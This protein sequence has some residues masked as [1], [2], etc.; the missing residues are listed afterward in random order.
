MKNSSFKVLCL[1]LFFAPITFLLSSYYL[2]VKKLKDPKEIIY[3]EINKQQEAWNKGD[4][5]GFMELYWHSDSL[6]FISKKGIKKGYNSVYEGYKK[7]YEQNN[8]MGT[9]TF[10]LFDINLIGKKDAIV[11]GSWKV[12]NKE[13]VFSGYFTLWFKKLEGNWK[14]VQDHTS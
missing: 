7:S 4:L 2:P 1:I 12:E 5:K 14:I 10:E 6:T 8:N 11:N 3:H 13:G 9:L